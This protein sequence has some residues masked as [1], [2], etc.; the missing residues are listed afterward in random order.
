MFEC[1]DLS[2][3]TR[4]QK[5]IYLDEKHYQNLTMK[6]HNCH[7]AIEG[8]QVQSDLLLW[9]ICHLEFNYTEDICANLTLDEYDAINNEVQERANNFLIIKEWLSAAPSLIWCLVAG[10]ILKNPLKIFIVQKLQIGN[11]TRF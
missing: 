7:Y 9:K 10:N 4:Y 1:F 2:S 5:E 8:G 11:F 3:L 6:F